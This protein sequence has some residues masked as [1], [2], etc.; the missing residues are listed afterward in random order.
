[1]SVCYETSA[2]RDRRAIFN[3]F[4]RLDIEP[5]LAIVFCERTRSIN[6]CNMFVYSIKKTHNTH[7]PYDIPYIIHMYY[8]FIYLFNLR[9]LWL[10]HRETRL[11]SCTHSES[12][13]DL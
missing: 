2:S 6:T 12:L 1:M 10:G 13:G 5:S 3:H 8:I 9:L 7:V 11:G 4:H